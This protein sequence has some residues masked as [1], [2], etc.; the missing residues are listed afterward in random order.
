MKQMKRSNTIKEEAAAVF[1]AG[2]LEEAIKKFE[3]CLDIDELNAQYN[4]T[5]L[6]NIAIAQ[7]KL[8]ATD[9]AIIA[10]N[11][12][13]QYNPRYAKAYVKRGEIYVSLEEYNEAIKDFGEAASIDQTGF[14]VH[15]KLKDAQRRQKQAAKKDYYKILGITDKNCDDAVIR[16]AYKKAALKWHPD[17]N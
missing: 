9:K 14:G 16:K 11:K 2:D 10:L 15:D 12:A 1:K 17:K 5:F 13:I 4:S 3:E 6:L 7:V 8:K